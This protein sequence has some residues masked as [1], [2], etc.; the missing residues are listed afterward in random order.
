[1]KLKKIISAALAGV[2]LVGSV[3]VGSVSAA[4]DSLPF[5]D[6]GK[7]K[8]FYSAVKYVYDEKIMDGTSKTL[9][10]PETG[11]TRAMF[12]TILGRMAGAE[13]KETDKFTDIKKNSWYSGYV[14]WAL[15]TGVV[16]GYP[17]G[18]FQPDKNLSREEMA[19]AVD[20][21]IDYLGVR[22]TSEG[23]MWSF[24][25]QKKVGKWAVDS[26]AVLRNS[27]VV[28]G[29]QY[30]NFNPKASITRAEAAT[31][32]MK[33]K[34]AIANAW[35][36]YL[37]TDGGDSL[38]FGASYIYANG[39][40]FAGGMAHE[41][42]KAGDLPVLKTSMSRYEATRTYHEAN[43]AG[44]SINYSEIDVTKYPFVKLAY[45]YNG[46]QGELSAVYSVD[47]TKTETRGESDT[48]CAGFVESLTLK[49]GADDEG[50]KT[51][52]LD[53]SAVNAAHKVNYSTQ[54]AN[55]LFK[56]CENS[57]D[58]TG[59]FDVLY[60]GFF[61]TQSAADAFTAGSDANIADYLKNYEHYSTV[62]Y[63]ELTDELD[64]KYDKL[65]ADRIK[66]IKNS[67]SAV[68]PEDIKAAG[69]KCYFI[70]SINGDD[71]NDGL[72]EKTPWKTFANLY[73]IKAGGRVIKYLPEP[74]SG[75]FFERGSEFYTEKYLNNSMEG[76]NG[77]GNS[78][79]NGPNVTYGAYGEGEKPL[80]TAALDFRDSGNTGKWVATEYPNVWKLEN[81]DLKYDWSTGRIEVGNMIF[82]DGE[83]VG[84]RI[85]PQ[86]EDKCF[87]EGETST[88]RAWRCNGYEYFYTGVSDLTNP[89]TALKHNLEYIHDMCEKEL[90]L[91]W[92]QGNP[93]DYFDDIKVAR[94]AFIFNSGDN[95][96]IDNLKISYGTEYALHPGANGTTVTN[97]E[98]SF[99]GGSRSSIES[100]SEIYGATKGS[101]FYDCYIHDIGDGAITSQSG[102]GSADA[103]DQ[104]EDIEY[105]GNVM[106]ACGHSV[107]IWNSVSNL[108]ENGYSINR[109]KNVLVK[110][111]IMAYNGY[112]FHQTQAGGD[113][114][115]GET[116]CGSMYGEFE[117][118][119]LEGNLFLH[120]YGNLYTA[121]M[122]TYEQPRGWMAKGN[123]YVANTYYYNIGYCYE[124]LNHIDHKMWKR[125]RV[126]F[127]YSEEGL[128][129]YTSL[130]IDPMG[131]YYYYSDNTDEY[132][133][134]GCFF[135]SGYYAERGGFELKER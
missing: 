71:R 4:D 91:Y 84:V 97:C 40:A 135:M 52:T 25:D 132:K 90:Y 28:E 73:E 99:V 33:L 133:E 79:T 55:L 76:F 123:T 67:E 85:M 134:K 75:V 50:M 117:N 20:R 113:N 120:G 118:C 94:N 48:N 88:D 24:T 39:S 124:T 66:E 17:D 5:K 107:E 130:G 63:Q 22:M 18:T 115:A 131:T 29:D 95:C 53:L 54:L 64:E 104:I 19:V 68:T 103:P 127:A 98:I 87:G 122:A 119:R 42:D 80:F 32:V 77:G 44:V 45:K 116:V 114:A 26:L 34:A 14:G 41:L 83:G 86:S 43:T 27:G 93:S 36:G 16:T 112:G 111:N 102:G 37:P 1:M 13:Q 65:L 35:Q 106:V 11:L 61:K 69:G 82:N 57:F 100:G 121:Y 126:S 49:A 101:Y 96:R 46:M 7:K 58:V 105:V 47:V 62:N 2:M 59:S 89:G 125:T 21:Y 8:W 23:G 38:I 109:I 108:D 72:S 128:A 70:S 3:L 110:D 60:I 129:W 51:A 15:E 92:D 10:E 74:G 31:I 9:F 78:G 81:D 12:I 6:V 56:P 30:G